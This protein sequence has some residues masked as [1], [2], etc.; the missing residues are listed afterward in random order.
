MTQEL[1]RFAETATAVSTVSARGSKT[2]RLMRPKEF[3]ES[4]KRTNPTASN[5]QIKA[6]FAA[7]LQ[8]EGMSQ[9]A[10]RFAELFLENKLGLTAVTVNAK[11]TGGNARFFIPQ[12]SA[13]MVREALNTLTPEELQ[14]VLAYIKENM[15]AE[16]DYVSEGPDPID[17]PEPIEG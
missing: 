17:I 1:V 2:I 9:S 15:P 3:K 14:D 7:Y 8:R 5:R 12:S 13:P 10:H 4:Y 11:N 6:A 16:A